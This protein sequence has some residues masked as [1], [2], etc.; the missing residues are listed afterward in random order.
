VHTQR[1][2]NHRAVGR[3]RRPVQLHDSLAWGELQELRFVS[4]GHSGEQRLSHVVDLVPASYSTRNPP[5]LP[6]GPG[7]GSTMRVPSTCS[8][9]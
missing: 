2:F 3:E 6:A 4:G 9:R 1:E 7:V 8:G 5:P